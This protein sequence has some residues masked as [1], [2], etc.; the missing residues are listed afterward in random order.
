M[1]E[2]EVNCLLQ[3]IPFADKNGWEQCRFNVYS[4]AQ[5]FSKKQLKPSDILKFEWDNT[6][7]IGEESNNHDISNEDIKRLTEISKHIKL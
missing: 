7:V 2:Y 4:V 6:D 5:M 1:Q 3:N